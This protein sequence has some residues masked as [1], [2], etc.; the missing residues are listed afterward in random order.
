MIRLPTRNVPYLA[1]REQTRYPIDILKIAGL[2][3]YEELGSTQRGRIR[4]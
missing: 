2:F 1:S 4:Y 3:L